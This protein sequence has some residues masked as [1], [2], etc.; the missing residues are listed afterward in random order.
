MTEAPTARP[1]DPS[2]EALRVEGLC[3]RFGAVVALDG[4]SVSFLRGEAHGVVGENGAGKSTLMR[5]L[6]GVE[7]PSAGSV[8]VRGAARW[9]RSPTEARSSGIAMIHQELSGVADLG[10]AENLFLGR[11]PTRRG[12]LD[13]RRMRTEATRWLDRLGGGI[14]PDARLVDL[15][16]AQRQRVEI[17]RALS[18]NAGLLILDEPTAGLGEQDRHAL[19][20]VLRDLKRRGMTLLFVSHDLDDVL[21]LCDRVT[22]LRDGQLV[23]TLDRETTA[24]STPSTLAKLMVGRPL[25]DHFPPRREPGDEV[26]LD[27]AGWTSRDVADVSFTVR[28]GEIFGLAGLMGAGRTELA[29]SLFGLRPATG[30]LRIGGQPVAPRGPRDAIAAGLAYLPEDRKESGLALDLSVAANITLASLRRY[31]RFVLDRQ[32]EGEAARAQ[33]GRLGI[34]APS[35]LAPVATLS[36][37]NQQKVLLA[38]WLDVRPRVL[39]VDEPTRGVDIGAKEDIY[40][41][42]HALAAEGLACVVI[43]SEL[44]ELLGLCHRIGVMRRGRLVAILDGPTATDHALLGHALGSGSGT[45]IKDH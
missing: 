28:R 18:E 24:A 8:F 10:V 15:P 27:V 2:P 3:K 6:A 12:M 40:R 36:G 29:E 14:D 35:E 21:A 5:I 22:V 43:S 32:A 11:E 17:A 44:N 39:I 42:L 16:M 1:A 34:R 33:I 37:G 25:A 38:K 19:F 20:A 30:T 41:Q 31:G 13:R 7:T 26:V 4:V 45:K 9:P 23:A